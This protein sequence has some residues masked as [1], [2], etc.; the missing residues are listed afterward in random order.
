MVTSGLRGFAISSGVGKGHQRE[1]DWL[2]LQ[3]KL[4][5]GNKEPRAE[6]YRP[7]AT[8]CNPPRRVDSTKASISVFFEARI[9]IQFHLS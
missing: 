4:G 2:Y 1:F 8:I 6:N 9:G 3:K 7:W 5:P